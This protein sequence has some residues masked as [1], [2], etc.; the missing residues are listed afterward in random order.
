MSSHQDP[1]QTIKEIL[2]AQNI[3]LSSLHE[4]IKT[5]LTNLIDLTKRMDSMERKLDIYDEYIAENEANDREDDLEAH[6]E[7]AEAGC[8]ICG[9]IGPPPG[10]TPIEDH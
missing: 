3:A 1:I 8:L 2:S 5:A 10:S 9:N 4:T 6:I 7:C